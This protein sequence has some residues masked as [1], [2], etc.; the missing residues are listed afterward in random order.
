MI[1][2]FDLDDTLYPEITYVQ[3]GFLTV[4]KALEKAFGWPA[5]ESY[6]WMMHRLNTQGRH[7]I[8]DAL[9]KERHV[10]TKKL[11]KQCVSIYRHHFPNIQLSPQAKACLRRFKDNPK[12]LV[13]DGHKIVQHLKIEALGLSSLM[14][15]CYITNRYGQHRAKP[16]PYC[17][18]QIC[19]REKAPTNQVV[20]I[21]DNP[22]KD[23]VGIKPLGFHTIRVLQG[24][25]KDLFLDDAHEAELTIES[26]DDL[27]I[28][29]INN[30]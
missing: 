21:S 4:A 20:Y 3:S 29:L 30:L 8:F 13:T 25:Y 17:F 7:Q 10:F 14:R 15:F 9:L 27:T 28:E 11:A 16:C 12:Y 18:L 22:N 6:Q 5:E 19:K 23:F 24:C 26:L 1:L 2:V